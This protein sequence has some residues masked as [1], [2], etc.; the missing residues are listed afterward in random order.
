MPAPITSLLLWWVSEW[1]SDQMAD[2]SKLFSNLL[3]LEKKIPVYY[4][5]L[6]DYFLLNIFI[7]THKLQNKLADAD[8]ATF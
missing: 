5:Y 2:K 3:F 6:F 7:Q 1:V 4:F 8:K